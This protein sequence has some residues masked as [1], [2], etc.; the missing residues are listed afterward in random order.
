M[1][2][3]IPN[4]IQIQIIRT[5]IEVID[6]SEMLPKSIAILLALFPESNFFSFLY[7]FFSSIKYIYFYQGGGVFI[8]Q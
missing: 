1:K 4:E 8:F 7:L 2:D 6:I 3:T 5:L